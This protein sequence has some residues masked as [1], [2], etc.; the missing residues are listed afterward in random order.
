M[1]VFD[2]AAFLAQ[3]AIKA[4]IVFAA[5]WG[6]VACCRRRA[7]AVHH[8]IWA[9]AMMV[10]LLIPLAALLSTTP[11]PLGRA[12]RLDVAP[13]PVWR[14]LLLGN[15]DPRGASHGGQTV[16]AAPSTSS[17]AIV[18]GGIVVWMLG[19]IVVLARLTRDLVHARGL[20]RRARP[21]DADRIGHPRV[22]AAESDEIATPMTA[23]VFRPVIL[24]PSGSIDRPSLDVRAA[25]EH[26][27]A[28]A[29]RYDTLFYV[30][31][32]VVV[33]CHW[34]NPLAWL[35]LARLRRDA[36]RACDDRAL[37][38][39]IAP[40]DYANIL[41]AAT[42]V[43]NRRGHRLPLGM[44]AVDDL[45]A[46]LTAV[47]RS[48]ARR[49]RCSRSVT[50]LLATLGLVG[51]A[52]GGVG[53]YASV[54][55]S[56]AVDVLPFEDSPVSGFASEVAAIE[57]S[58]ARIPT[59]LNRGPQIRKN[60]EM[61][62]SDAALARLLEQGT[63]HVPTHSEDL[64]AER[65]RW[66]LS[67]ARGG[68]LVAPL[69][70]LVLSPNE[71]DAAY[72]AWALGLADRNRAFEP[73]LNAL[74]HRAWRVRAEAAASLSRWADPLAATAMREAITDE[75]WQVR[76]EVVA[77]FGALGDPDSLELVRL[78]RND[79]HRGVRM[80]ADAVVASARAR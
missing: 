75:A 35:G 57:A 36:E 55:G 5:A 80:Q 10:V 2:V 48:R 70:E 59:A 73:L 41:L 45:E 11:T 28:H 68:Q 61:E 25:L 3:N 37:E 18:A 54:P 53:V 63:R 15:P 64:V 12:V 29:A 62:T 9:A 38:S 32:R 72:A 31:G 71:R 6:L 76:L 47:L 60:S 23:G 52:I 34:M 27:R 51:V 39:G 43:A 20:V 67:Q 49:E 16:G 13:D 33:A 24:L 58:N 50:S 44:A 4:A 78:S 19:A 69:I 30:V 77:Y 56:E 26:E 42:I 74:K 65:S 79:S 21:I 22:R 7:A 17:P 1:N 14:P 66:A 46:R 40:V 8:A